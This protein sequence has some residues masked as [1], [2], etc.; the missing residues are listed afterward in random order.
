MANSIEKDDEKFN[1][2]LVKQ[3]PTLDE[4]V[5]S[6][7]EQN[8]I[9]DVI[10]SDDEKMDEML[11]LESLSEDGQPEYN[12]IEEKYEVEIILQ[13]FGKRLIT[14]LQEE[15]KEFLQGLFDE[16]RED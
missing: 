10:E 2:L 6:V 7:K 5:D 14:G 11:L 12:S 9:K 13:D 4:F 1:N 15:N 8:P 3:Y 16:I